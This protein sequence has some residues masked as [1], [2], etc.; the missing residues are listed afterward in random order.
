MDIN[1]YALLV[2]E[3]V[4]KNEFL[5]V[6]INVVWRQLLDRVHVEHHTHL[7]TVMFMIMLAFR[8][9]SGL[10]F[11]DQIITDKLGQL[12]GIHIS[13]KQFEEYFNNTDHSVV[14]TSKFLVCEV[15]EDLQ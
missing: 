12:C 1:E 9:S 5:L 13:K 10:R 4:V 14:Y 2:L 7:E 11:K 8:K 3:M 15:F 6:E